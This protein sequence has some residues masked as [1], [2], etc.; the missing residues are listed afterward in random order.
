MAP[1]SS[2]WQR[3]IQCTTIYAAKWRV[4][5]RNGQPAICQDTAFPQQTCL[6]NA[7]NMFQQHTGK[8]LDGALKIQIWNSGWSARLV[9]W[10]KAIFLNLQQLFIRISLV[11]CIAS[12]ILQQGAWLLLRKPLA[13]TRFLGCQLKTEVI[14]GL[15]KLWQKAL[16]RWS[17]GSKVV[18]WFW[19]PEFEILS[20]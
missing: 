19:P 13:K 5:S 8:V 9:W 10:C 6:N 15:V 12:L 7:H 18:S 4:L 17:K 16:I 3:F 20:T 1:Q 2:R 11:R 14:I